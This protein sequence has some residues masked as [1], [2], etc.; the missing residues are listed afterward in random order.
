MI[1]FK[2]LNTVAVGEAMVELAPVG[3][4]QLRRGFVGDTFNTA[5]HM[6]Q[7]LPVRDRFTL[8]FFCVSPSP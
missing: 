3:E 6:A 1:D 2:S 4:G 5:W 8:R 7:A